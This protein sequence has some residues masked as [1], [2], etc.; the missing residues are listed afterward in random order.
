LKRLFDIFLSFIA[1]IFLSPLFL[2]VAAVVKVTSRGPVFYRARRVGRGGRLFTLYKFR[3]M[4]DEKPTSRITAAGD[5]RIT[6]LGRVLRNFKI[7]E[8]PQLF[9]VLKGDMSLVGPRP[10]DPSYVER[11]A[12][13]QR[14]VLD[15]RP[16]LT[17]V[18]SIA[19]R[20]EEQL[21]SGEDSEALYVDTIMPDKLRRELDY[22]DRRSFWSDLGVLADTIRAV[23]RG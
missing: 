9:N 2:V 21:L 14:R 17:S 19:Y 16:G 12:P 10:E 13:E 15:V 4:R 7:D 23:F 3:T 11:Y 20:D 18:A 5:P 1:L 22:L 6:S 8:L